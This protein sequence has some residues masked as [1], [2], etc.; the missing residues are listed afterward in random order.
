VAVTGDLMLVVERDNQRVQVFRLPS[1]EP[2]GAFGQAR[3]RR[4]YGLTVFP[5]AGESG[6]TLYVTDAYEGPDESIP[7][8]SKLGE[9]VKQYRFA[10][11]GDTLTHEHVRSFGAT[12]GAGVL[13]AVESIWADPPNDR[14]LVAEEREDASQIKV[15]TLEGAFTG[16]TIGTEYFPHEAEGIGLYRCADGSG[17][18]VTTDQADAQSTFHVFDRTSLNYAGS[19]Q[20][21]VVANTDGIFVTERAFGP[22]ERGA[23]YAV[24]DDGNTAAFAWADIT[25]ALGFGACETASDA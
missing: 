9:R 14:L 5:A 1:F 22:F 19:F 8:P 21:P 6:Y 10:V 4:P 17:H 20:G 12:S 7:P 23:V 11:A 24:H 16:T 3:L 15:Y 13:K 2:V 25:D 18:W